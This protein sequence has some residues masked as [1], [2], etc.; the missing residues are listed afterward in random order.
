MMRKATLYVNEQLLS[1]ILEHL[2]NDHKD[3]KY[4]Q[5]AG[6]NIFNW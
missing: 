1:D 6:E 5:E 4:L 3:R 2:P